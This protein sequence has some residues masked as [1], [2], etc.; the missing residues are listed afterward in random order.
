MASEETFHAGDLLLVR[1]AGG[2]EFRKRAL[3]PAVPG[4]DFVVVWLC[5][6][7]EWASAKAEGRKPDARPWPVEDVQVAL[8]YE[9]GGS[10]AHL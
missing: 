8:S 4:H 1:D 6:E 9:E 2:R 7:E 3:G 5:S 10:D